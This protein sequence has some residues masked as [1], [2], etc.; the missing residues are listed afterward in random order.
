[1]HYYTVKIKKRQSVELSLSCK[2]YLQMWDEDNLS[3]FLHKYPLV[4]AL[5]N[6]SSSNYSRFLIG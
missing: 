4:L 2:K 1:M 6:S 3:I 5:T